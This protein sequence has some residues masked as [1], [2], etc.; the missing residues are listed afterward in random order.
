MAKRK[1]TYRRR[2][3]SFLGM[4]NGIIGPIAGGAL[5]RYIAN[6]GMLGEF[7]QPVANIG[8]GMFL[9]SKFCKDLGFYQLGGLL[10]GMISGNGNGG[11]LMFE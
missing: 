8:V 2:A 6:S 1:T 10:G 4:G 7:G 3:S 9:K 5:A 11:G